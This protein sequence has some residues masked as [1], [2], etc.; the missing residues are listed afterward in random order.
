MD[1]RFRNIEA[2]EDESAALDAFLAGVTGSA[3]G[4]LAD[5]PLRYSH[6]HLL[7]PALHALQDRMGWISAGGLD[8]LC[9]RLHVP[10]AD[11]Y[12][13]ASFYSLLALQEQPPTRTHTCIDLA[14]QLSGAIVGPD[15]HA[16]PCLGLCDQAP[17]KLTIA[18]GAAPS[19]SVAVAPG[20]GVIESGPLLRRVGEI[21]PL[22]LDEHLATGGHAA[23]RT[24]VAIGGSAVIQLVH[25]AKLLGRGGAAFPAGRKWEAVARHI[26]VAHELIC[27]ADESEP[28]TFKDRVLL[29]GDPYAVIE[30]MTIAGFATGTERGWIYVRAEYPVARDRLS[31][32]ISECRARG[33]LG[34]DVMGLGFDFD[35][36][37]FRGAG[38]YICG[39]ETAIFN[40]IEGYRGEPRAKP[41]FPVDVGL[42][43]RHTLVNNV[44]TLMN[45]LPIIGASTTG[46][47]WQETKLFCVSGRVTRPG[48]Y[49]LPFGITLRELLDRAGATAEIQAVLLGGAAGAF[50][51]PDELDVPLTFDGARDVR[52]T[53]GS[54]VVM[55]LSAGDSMPRF[56]HRIAEFFADESCGQCVPCRVGAVRQVELLDRVIAPS[57]G[58]RG[59]L[60]HGAHDELTRVL[61]DASICGLGQTAANAVQSAI[62]KGLV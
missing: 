15:E 5:T 40:S 16:S 10:P 45:V 21:D 27:N 34:P 33:L 11:A 36:Q 38:A 7:L 30:A 23:L 42:F 18:A 8:E 9:R 13:V 19:F 2:S 56:L 44:E 61:Q 59:A 47:N 12:G 29:E 25:D 35:I 4:S 39:E 48:V 55:V 32:A 53:L 6:R 41:P 57:N 24:A 60:D 20:G 51:T 49:E 58:A 54:G 37:V 1:L 28:G 3:S 26:G 50:V 31:H 46:D 14:C 22:S 62:Q 52:A 17:A 43:G